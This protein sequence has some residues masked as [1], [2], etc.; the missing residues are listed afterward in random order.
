ML[1]DSIITDMTSNDIQFYN[2]KIKTMSASIIH[3]SK[4]HIRQ[5]YD[6]GVKELLDQI[7]ITTADTVSTN[8]NLLELEA[9]IE[10]YFV[11][12]LERDIPT[13]LEKAI[14]ETNDISTRKAKVAAV[15]DS[16]KYRVGF[17]L[18]S[19]FTRAYNLGFL[20]KAKEMNIS[21]IE[22]VGDKKCEICAEHVGKIY[23]VEEITDN[24]LPPYHTNCTC[25]IKVR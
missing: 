15:F 20:N 9:K 16:L 7:G 24:N 11:R 19:E 10:R 1:R 21:E 22:L 12:L 18:R 13:Q 5:S 3:S 17:I 4:S 14:K 25:K 2:L 8:R 6:N 23:H